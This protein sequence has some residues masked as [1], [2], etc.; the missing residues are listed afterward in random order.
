M[1]GQFFLILYRGC[2]PKL[3]GSRVNWLKWNREEVST[4][5]MALIVVFIARVVC[6]CRSR[7][8]TFANWAWLLMSYGI[9]LI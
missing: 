3:R 8:H 9:V 7:T 6:N 1:I 4:L 5:L 2:K